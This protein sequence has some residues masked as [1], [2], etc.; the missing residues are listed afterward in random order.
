LDIALSKLD[1]RK[2]ELSLPQIADAY[3]E[4][5]SLRAEL[6]ALR[7]R[8]S[9]ECPVC[10]GSGM[11]EEHNCP[12][13]N[14]TGRVMMLDAEEVGA[15]ICDDPCCGDLGCEAYRAVLEGKR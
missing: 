3:K 11:A 2:D 10:G 6:T 4:L 9:T 1:K 14:G 13:C 15:R 12:R 7:N 8:Y 5:E